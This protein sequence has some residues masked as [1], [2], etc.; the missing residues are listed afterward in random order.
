LFRHQ[1]YIT[2]IGPYQTAS[3]T[4]DRQEEKHTALLKYLLFH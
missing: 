1:L 3:S 2:C 4:A